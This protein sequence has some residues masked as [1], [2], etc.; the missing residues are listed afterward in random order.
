M[1]DCSHC[2]PACCTSE[3]CH[4]RLPHPQPTQTVILFPLVPCDHVLLPPAVPVV[5]TDEPDSLKALYRRGQAHVGQGSWSEAVE[6]LSRAA[7]L[8]PASDPAQLRLI[9]EKLQDAKDALSM[10]RAAAARSG[11]AAGT[12]QQSGSGKGREE[13]GEVEEVIEINAHP[14]AAAT[15]ET[16]AGLGASSSS[17]HAG[18]SSSSSGL[19]T[20]STQQL[21]SAAMAAAATNGGSMTPE[22]MRAAA[23]MMRNNPQWASQVGLVL[24]AGG[25]VRMR[26]CALGS[27]RGTVQSFGL[28]LLC[29]SAACLRPS[30]FHAAC[31]C[32]VVITSDQISTAPALFPTTPSGGCSDVKHE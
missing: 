5:T 18:S 8:C 31:D 9:R 22:A 20:H 17:E 1:W 2:T 27:N 14:M 28:A 10:Q 32:S 13:D 23:D 26:S 11:D 12:V 29:V 30:H 6:D 24:A 21:A 15:A 25:G 19:S 4:T 16:I 3:S 7:K